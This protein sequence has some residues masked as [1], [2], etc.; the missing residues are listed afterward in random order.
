MRCLRIIVIVLSCFITV[1]CSN[2]NGWSVVGSSLLG[3]CIDYQST[4]VFPVD[5]EASIYIVLG[6]FLKKPSQFDIFDASN[7]QINGYTSDDVFGEV[8]VERRK[9]VIKIVGY[10]SNVIIERKLRR[11]DYFDIVRS[12]SD[13]VDLSDPD[14]LRNCV[15]DAFSMVLGQEFA[16]DFIQLLELEEVTGINRGDR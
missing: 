13:K 12:I 3:L 14:S 4:M 6:D 9:G 1:A 15:I 5:D 10:N 11:T 8:S 2:N 16:D 7:I